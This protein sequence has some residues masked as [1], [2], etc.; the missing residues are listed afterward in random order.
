MQRT[1][2][3]WG[4]LAAQSWEGFRVI[5]NCRV[6]PEVMIKRSKTDRG[7]GCIAQDNFESTEWEYSGRFNAG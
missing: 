3:D 7:D 1:G 2:E 5:V 4:F 6:S